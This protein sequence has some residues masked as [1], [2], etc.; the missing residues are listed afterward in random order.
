MTNFANY[1]TKI[2]NRTSNSLF[3]KLFTPGYTDGH[4][5]VTFYLGDQEGYYPVG[6]EVHTPS[7]H[8]VDGY[9]YDLEL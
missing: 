3:S 6:I 1:E 9:V 5:K 7:E 2:V 4:M 8:T